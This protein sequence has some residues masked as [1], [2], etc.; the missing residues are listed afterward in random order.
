MTQLA[1]NDVQVIALLALLALAAVIDYGQHRIPNLLTGGGIAAGLAL[2]LTSGGSGALGSAL[3]GLAVGGL[4]LLPFYAKGAM[5]AGDV[6]L[7]ALVGTY[8]GP[9]TTVLAVGATLIVGGVIAF[10]LLLVKKGARELLERYRTMLF[11]VTVTRKLHYL[12]PDKSAAAAR[13]FPYAA[14]IALGSTA[15]LLYT[16]QLDRVLAMVL[17]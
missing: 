15:V 10:G 8:L 13:R 1:I 6:K 7:M 17:A 14:A 3:A 5:G 9:L 2:A 16:S 11:H 4:A 12:P